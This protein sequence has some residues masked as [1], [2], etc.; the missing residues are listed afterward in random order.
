MHMHRVLRYR[1]IQIQYELRVTSY[2][3]VSLYRIMAIKNWLNC[4]TT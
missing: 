4:N 1:N 2:E 3:L